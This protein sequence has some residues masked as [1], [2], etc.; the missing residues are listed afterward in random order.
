M[1]DKLIIPAKINVGFQKRDDTYTGKL[2][3]VIYYDAK[4]VLRKQKSWDSWRNPKLGNVEYENIPTSGFVLNKKVGDYKSDWNHRMA[5]IRVYDPRDF[6]FEISVEN[7]LF[8]LTEC[9]AIKG[10]GLE[11]EFVYSWR[12]TELVLLPVSS[13][14]YKASSSFS[15][16]QSKKIGKNGVKEG[17]IYKTK[18]NKQVMYLG[19]HDFYIF[20]VTY[21]AQ[22]HS[23]QLRCAKKHGFLFVDEADREE[24]S[25]YHKTGPYWIQTGFTKLAECLSEEVSPD[26]SDAYDKFKK[27][28]YGSPFKALVSK[29]AVI[30]KRENY[31]KERS[32]FVKKGED[33]YPIY[34]EYPWGET[35]NYT[36]TIGTA[37]VSIRDG[38]VDAPN[39]TLYDEEQGASYWNPKRSRKG[40]PLTQ[41]EADVLEVFTLHIKNEAGVII[42]I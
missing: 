36:V 8:I 18:D 4:G 6:E 12:G 2:A 10:K 13:Q 7:L 40:K 22:G 20:D 9:S 41:E 16:L 35:K 32:L 5:H 11:G 38:N 23:Y 19:R 37:P 27:S 1:Q 25:Y 28:K 42:K 33:F 21:P 3:Y 30:P 39:V 14:D 17:H 24:D 26:F 34:V 15:E 29:A 31:N